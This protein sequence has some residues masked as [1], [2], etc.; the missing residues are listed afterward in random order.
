MNQRAVREVR[1]SADKEHMRIPHS[2]AIVRDQ[3]PMIAMAVRPC[4]AASDKRSRPL[5]ASSAGRRQHID[6]R[7]VTSCW[8]TSEICVDNIDK[9]LYSLRDYFPYFGTPEVEFP[10]TSLG[11]CKHA[12]GRRCAVVRCRSRNRRTCSDCL[13]ESNYYVRFFLLDFNIDQCSDLYASPAP[14]TSNK[15][16]SIIW[17]GS[18]RTYK[19]STADIFPRR[20][21]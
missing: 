5:P 6:R 7:C 9:Q 11:R 16:A 19:I 2:R 18:H 10:K 14:T 17:M 21:R 13:L 20:V 8:V 15:F 4:S 3:R 1:R 12:Q